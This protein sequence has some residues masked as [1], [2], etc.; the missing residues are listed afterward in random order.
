M[1][2]LSESIIGNYELEHEFHGLSRALTVAF[3]QG[4]KAAPWYITDFV[5][6]SRVSAGDALG[7]PANELGK[8]LQL[9]GIGKE[10]Q[11]HDEEASPGLYATARR[12][13]RARRRKAKR[14]AVARARRKAGLAEISKPGT[15]AK[16][17]EWVKADRVAFCGMPRG[18]DGVQVK[19]VATEHG[20][21]AH[22]GNVKLCGQVWQCPVC[23]A[24]IRA[25]RAE[26]LADGVSRWSARG[27]GFLFVTQTLRHKHGDDL[28]ELL[29]ILARSQRE[30]ISQS[31]WWRG[32]RRRYGL[33]GY[34]RSLEITL[35]ANGWHPHH[36]TLW[37]TEKPMIAEEAQALAD[38]LRGKW[39][40]AVTRRGGRVPN[41]HGADVKAVSAAEVD[42]L[43]WYLAKEQ[44]KA[45]EL[46]E[47]QAGSLAAE[48]ARG[49]WKGGYPDGSVTPFEL[50]DL[51]GKCAAQLWDEYIT[52]TR[53]K[54]SVRWSAG[55]RGRLGM[56]TEEKS[57]AEIIDEC[58]AQ[59]FAAFVIERRLYVGEVLADPYKEARVLELAEAGADIEIAAALIG[60]AVV[61]GGA[62]VPDPG[63]GS[64]RVPLLVRRE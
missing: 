63:G 20:T 4:G 47:K 50:L 21:A 42:G 60:A 22:Y 31:S 59:G 45:A 41:E 51:T 28:A 19:T 32:V 40:D 10:S 49:D 29:D 14:L 55:L 37:F 48:V 24:I 3:G 46:T 2:A 25:G 5:G 7:E 18:F 58:E 9:F 35:G 44:V 33:V 54:S 11:N 23:S 64:M 56:D 61:P 16:S 26:E 13:R 52:A 8:R 62:W 15:N 43:P 12:Q 36:H 1:G 30:G 17:E 57:D 34:V 39:A 38:E 53:G 27:G 6:G